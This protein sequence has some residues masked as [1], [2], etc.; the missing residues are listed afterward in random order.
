MPASK[1][2]DSGN[3]ATSPRATSPPAE[4]SD[5][6]SIHDFVPTPA[7]VPSRISPGSYTPRASALSASIATSSFHHPRAKAA[8]PT[9]SPS[10][11]SSKTLGG[12]P[13]SADAEER[14]DILEPFR[15]D[16]RD[17]KDVATSL[18]V[19]DLEAQMERR[20]QKR[21]AEAETTK[22]ASAAQTAPPATNGVDKPLTPPASKARE[23]TTASNTT[24]ESKK[25]KRK[26][27]FDIQPDVV[28]IKRDVTKEN[29][30]AIRQ[31]A[32]A[33]KGNEGAISA[34]WLHS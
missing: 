14:N 27:T 13:G 30:E 1:K 17:G 8:S 26:V 9:G 4:Y 12:L 33:A 29:D 34:I 10:T 32:S 7:V 18:L 31:S 11:A 20:R 3:W 23:S 28:T 25:G 21:S 2:R 16:L 22:E 19:L 5:T 6:V 15:R 24:P